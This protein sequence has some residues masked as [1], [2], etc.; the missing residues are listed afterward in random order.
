MLV[1]S[2]SLTSVG[3]LPPRSVVLLLPGPQG[4]TRMTALLLLPIND[5]EPSIGLFTPLSKPCP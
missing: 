4:H 3:S 2:A 5:A 1:R